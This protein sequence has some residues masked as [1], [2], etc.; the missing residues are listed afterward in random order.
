MW[1]KLFCINII[2]KLKKGV[3]PFFYAVS[4]CFK[5]TVDMGDF[6]NK[7]VEFVN[8]ESAIIPL[9]INSEYVIIAVP[10]HQYTLYGNFQ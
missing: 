3:K 2:Y 5:N 9:H 4:F 7:L 1:G 10:N 8:F 6:M